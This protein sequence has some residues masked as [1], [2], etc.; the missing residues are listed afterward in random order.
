M[1]RPRRPGP[2]RGLAQPSEGDHPM[3]DDT[4]LGGPAAAFPPTRG[5]LVRAAAGNDAAVRRGAFA[6]LVEA[7]WKPVYKYLR[8]KRGLAN[9][10]AKDPTQAFFVRGLFELAVEDFRRHCATAGKEVHFKVF[11]RYDLDGPD[12]EERP[13][14]AELG[15][16]FN[17][18]ETQV[19]NYLAYARRRFRGFVLNRLRATTG[20]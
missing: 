6:E 16:E 8:L 15:Q 18:P 11:E 17:L 9:E 20:S 4:D 14:Y 3:R 12:A 2:R 1:G 5:S 7:Y 10:D 19:T 13:T